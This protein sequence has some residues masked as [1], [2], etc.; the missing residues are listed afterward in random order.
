MKPEPCA[1]T[2]AFEVESPTIYVDLVMLDQRQN[3]IVF[4]VQFLKMG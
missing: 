4:F 3:P 2:T 1:D